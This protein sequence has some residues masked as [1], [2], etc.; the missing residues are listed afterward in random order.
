MAFLGRS[1]SDDEGTVATT[2]RLNKKS[3]EDVSYRAATSSKGGDGDDISTGLIVAGA[4]FLGL[5]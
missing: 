2:H 3:D 4:L 1:Y 5:F